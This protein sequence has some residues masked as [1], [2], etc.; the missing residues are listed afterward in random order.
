[1]THKNIVCCYMNVYN[2]QTRKMKFE[3]FYWIVHDEKGFQKEIEK[4]RFTIK[5]QSS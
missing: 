2:D 1:M 5:K 3:T 4:L